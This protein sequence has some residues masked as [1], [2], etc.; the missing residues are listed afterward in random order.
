MDF[1]IRYGLSLAIG[2]FTQ[3]VK[4]PESARKYLGVLENIY[5]NLEFV[6][7][8]LGSQQPHQPLA[9]APVEPHA[10]LPV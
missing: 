5:H 10:E 4:N 7:V 1:F 8:S 3:F 6:L 9:E 2:L